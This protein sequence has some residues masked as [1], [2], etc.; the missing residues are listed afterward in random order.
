MRNQVAVCIHQRSGITVR[1][2]HTHPCPICLGRGLHL[3]PGHAHVSA[4]G[5]LPVLTTSAARRAWAGWSGEMGL[6]HE[7]QTVGLGNEPNRRGWRHG[8]RR[9]LQHLLPALA[10][11]L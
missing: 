8:A 9:D 5:S 11:E 3:D 6:P 2:G 1:M 4:A 7:P 10:R